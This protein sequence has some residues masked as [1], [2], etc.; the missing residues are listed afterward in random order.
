MNFIWYCLVALMI[1]GY[2]ILDGYDIGA[3]IVH[4][5]VAKGED[6]RRMILRSI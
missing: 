2:V 4:L 6:E 5:F 3:G 1:A